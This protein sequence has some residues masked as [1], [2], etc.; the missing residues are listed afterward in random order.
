MQLTD[1]VHTFV[2]VHKAVNLLLLLGLLMKDGMFSFFFLG[3][4]VGVGIWAP[5]GEES[6]HDKEEPEVPDYHALYSPALSS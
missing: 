1:Y 6:G 5:R 4:G 3:G 2:V